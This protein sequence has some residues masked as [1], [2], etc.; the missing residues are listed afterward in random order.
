MALTKLQ[1]RKKI[2][3]RIRK[4]ISGTKEKPRLAVFR[5][6]KHMYAQL[7]DDTAGHTLVAASSR[8][9]EVTSEKKAS[10]KDQA[11]R[12]G[13]LLAEKALAAGIKHV[14]FDRSGYLYHGRVKHLADAAREGGLK[15]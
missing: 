13:K 2:K 6:N 15:F 11:A 10:G 4:S 7:I 8:N 1:R 3:M 9:K 5:S 14:V 12:V